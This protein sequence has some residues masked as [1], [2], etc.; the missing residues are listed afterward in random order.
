MDD[1]ITPTAADPAAVSLGLLRR[2][3][4]VNQWRRADM[5]RTPPVIPERLRGLAASFLGSSPIRQRAYDVYVRS[6]PGQP[7]IEIVLPT[8]REDTT[9][10]DQ[11][12]SAVM[13]L[14]ALERSS[15]E[16]IIAAI[17]SV[18]FD[19][20]FSRVPDTLVLDNSIH[21]EIAANHIR[22]MRNLLAANA[23]T[24]L[25]PSPFFP[26]L[27]KQATDYAD[28]CR[29][30][31]TFKG[32]FGFTIKSP[33]KIND[34]PSLPMVPTEAPFE[35]RVIERFARGVE[36]VHRAA[37][38]GDTKL[39]TDTV[40][41][42]FSANACEQFANLIEDTSPGGMRIAFAF[43]P[44][45]QVSPGLIMTPEYEVG[46]KHIEVTRAAAKV[47]RERPPPNIDTVTGLIFDLHS[48]ND[49]LGLF[50]GSRADQTI[51]L[52]WRPEGISG[53]I[54]VSVRLSQEDYD[55]AVEAHRQGIPVT[56]KGLLEQ[57]GARS[58]ELSNITSFV[59]E[60]AKAPP[61]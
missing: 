11:I 47:L 57:R 30:A 33:L 7:E 4:A 25:A 50:G 59:V 32:S 6:K 56:V 13:K 16:R 61:P 5:P 27:V 36:A 34:E 10:A 45:W 3:L 55:K 49:P 60:D 23:T 38:Q 51:V 54:K 41:T 44:E 39:I 17:R 19:R 29:F 22:D 9:S 48:R 52:S 26:K 1:L 21:L 40:S 53:E 24:E 14:A 18:G 15:P 8:G 2:Y 20:V 35:R 28:N 12:E 37:E 43:S 42:G 31:H 46:L 58:W